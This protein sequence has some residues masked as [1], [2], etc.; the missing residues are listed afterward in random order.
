MTAYQTD[1]A[2]PAVEVPPILLVPGLDNSGPDHWQTLWERDDPYCDRVDLGRSQLNK[3]NTWV[4]HLNLAIHRAGRPVVLVAHSLGCLVAAWW[5]RL[6]QP[7]WG[8]PVLG[9][10]LVAPAAVDFFP[11]DERASVF[12]PTPS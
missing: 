7:A 11:L 12:A 3:K 1:V 6:E 8:D 5:A 2:R 4:N 10:L 9:A